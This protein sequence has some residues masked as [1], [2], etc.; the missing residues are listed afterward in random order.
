MR[1]EAQ[2]TDSVPTVDGARCLINA[3]AGQHP[4][5]ADELLHPSRR[6]ARRRRHPHRSRHLRQLPELDVPASMFNDPET[7]PDWMKRRET[8]KAE[9]RGQLASLPSP[10][11]GL[12][13]RR[14]A[15]RS[16]G[17]LA[18][19]VA[20]QGGGG[21]AALGR[22]RSRTGSSV[23]ATGVGYPK[24]AHRRRIGRLPS[25]LSADRG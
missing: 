1:V 4:P 6:T 2:R 15:C 17:S 8:W 3:R 22:G 9:D 24:S 16:H 21:C 19:R 14:P 10:Q 18:G 12:S 13:Q 7:L 11:A 23:A 20:R 25:C 5:V